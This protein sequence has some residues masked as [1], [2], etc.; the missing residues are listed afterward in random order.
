MPGISSV[1]SAR[2]VTCSFMPEV[3]K[4]APVGF[5]AEADTGSRPSGCTSGC[6]MRPVCQSCRNINPSLAWT[7]AVTRAQASTWASFQIPGV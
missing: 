6:E 7:A 5:T 4:A 2:G 3:V 1:S